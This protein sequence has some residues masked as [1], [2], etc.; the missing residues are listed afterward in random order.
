MNV[1]AMLSRRRRLVISS[2]L[3]LVLITGAMPLLNFLLANHYTGL[4]EGC[5]GT[6]QATTDRHVL[7]L[8]TF[9]NVMLIQLE[10]RG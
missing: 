10:A 4:L 9:C 6:L 7:E 3:L 8:Q 5:V 1:L 2:A